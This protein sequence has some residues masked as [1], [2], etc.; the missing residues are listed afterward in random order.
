MT[1]RTV[2][3]VAAGFVGLTVCALVGRTLVGVNGIATA[4]PM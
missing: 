4:A 1:I 3:V 2:L